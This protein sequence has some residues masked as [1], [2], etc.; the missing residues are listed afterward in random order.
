MLKLYK[1]AV[2]IKLQDHRYTILYD[3]VYKKKL[4]RC[5]IVLSLSFNYEKKKKII[6]FKLLIIVRKLKQKKIHSSVKII[7]IIIIKLTYFQI[8]FF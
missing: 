5:Y 7:T 3:K 1:W 4:F 8:V 2:Y 6:M